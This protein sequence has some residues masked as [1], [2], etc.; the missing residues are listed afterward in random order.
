MPDTLTRRMSLR[1]VT[2]IA[3][4]STLLVRSEHSASADGITAAECVAANEEAGPLRHAGKLRESR[5]SLRRCSAQKCP[6][7]VRKDCVAGAA[8]ADVDMPT[9]A[10]SV[11]DA[12]GSDLSAVKVTID[13]QPLADKLEG[14]ALEVDPGDHL[15]AFDSPGQPHVEKRLVIIEGEKNRKERIQMGEPPQV[16][17]AVIAPPAA[18]IPRPAPPPPNP[19]RTAGLALGVAGLGLAAAGGVSGLVAVLSWNS[20]KTA[21]GTNF[22]TTCADIPTARSDRSAAVV[23]GTLADV[24]LGLGAAALITGAALVL[25]APVNSGSATATGIR[26]APDV[27]AGHGGLMVRGVF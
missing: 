9:V 10:F 11:H 2:A 25:S 15:F 1:V 6:A 24:T 19:R 4:A 12:A 18:V 23:A 13:G 17:V 26:L 3:V 16:P 22:Q 14:T 8:Q 21:C 20:A 7:V 5:A 27:G